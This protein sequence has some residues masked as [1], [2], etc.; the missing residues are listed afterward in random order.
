MNGSLQHT[1]AMPEALGGGLKNPN[2]PNIGGFLRVCGLTF[3]LTR[4]LPD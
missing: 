3:D 1:G 4:S 2:I